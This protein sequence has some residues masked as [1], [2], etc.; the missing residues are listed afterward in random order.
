MSRVATRRPSLNPSSRRARRMGA[1]ALACASIV[2]ASC[3][4]GDRK[5]YFTPGNIVSFGDENSAFA[6]FSSANVEDGNGNPATLKGLSYAVTAI[7]QAVSTCDNIVS[8]SLCSTTTSN[9]FDSGVA[10]TDTTRY[11]FNGSSSSVT[12]IARDGGNNTQRT[13]VTLYSC[14]TSRNWVQ[15]VTSAYGKSFSADCSLDSRGGA[16]NYAV[17]GAK[18]ADVIAQ[19]NAHRG[20]I[21]SKTVVT[22]MAGQNDI[23]EQYAV[24][25]GGNEAGAIAVLQARADSMAAAIKDV[26]GTGAKVVLALTPDLGQTP[27][28]VNAGTTTVLTNLVRAYNDRLY[29]T[30]LGNVSGRSLAGVNPESLTK[31]GTRSSSYQYT[32]ALCDASAVR[33]PDGEPVDPVG[34]GRTDEDVANEKLLYCNSQYYTSG[35]DVGTAMWADSKRAGPVLHSLIGVTVY[36]RA[37]EQF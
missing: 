21:N 22:I 8:P 18:T 27:L 20:E 28:A 7:V 10:V 17:A 23:L 25:V 16:V 5:S 37:R 2:L 12:A 35:A 36:N 1:V 34:P 4:G 14:D 19:I 11:M 31:P 15:I 32:T 24:A 3:G 9:T 26:I 6:T 30:G 13:T 33:R 29:I